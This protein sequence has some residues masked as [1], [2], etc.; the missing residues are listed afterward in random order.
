MMIKPALIIIRHLHELQ[1]RTVSDKNVLNFV[2]FVK[3]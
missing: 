3:Q 1:F 2:I